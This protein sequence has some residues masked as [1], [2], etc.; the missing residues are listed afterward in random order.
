M[1]DSNT[2]ASSKAKFMVYWCDG[3][4]GDV[5]CRVMPYK[6]K[7]QAEEKFSRVKMD[8]RISSKQEAGVLLA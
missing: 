7:E 8:I 1:K 6:T 5:D 4:R 2:S 3:K